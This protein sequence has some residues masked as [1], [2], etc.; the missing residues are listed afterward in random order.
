MANEDGQNLRSTGSLLTGEDIAALN[1]K[2][3]EGFGSRLQRTLSF[4]FKSD[5]A[6]AGH[7]GPVV[8]AKQTK[9]DAAGNVH[10]AMKLQDQILAEV[11]PGKADTDAVNVGQLRAAL[12]CLNLTNILADCIDDMEGFGEQS[13]PVCRSIELTNPVEVS[14]GLTSL[15]AVEVWNGFV[16]VLGE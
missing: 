12:T 1:E 6:Q 11:A 7:A 13:K 9:K 5:R 8:I 2:V 10:P 15:Y 16:Y 14:T 3:N 4:F